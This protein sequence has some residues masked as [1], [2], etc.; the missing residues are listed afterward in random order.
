[1]TLFSLRRLAR[2]APVLAALSIAIGSAA[3]ASA[4]VTCNQDLGGCYDRAGAIDGFWAR[5]SY[6]FDCDYTF[7]QCVI[8][9][10]EA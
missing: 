6:V 7:A 10:L 4:D 3:P 9:S 2:L 5:T 8:R 1:M